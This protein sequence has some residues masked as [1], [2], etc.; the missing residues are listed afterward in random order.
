MDADSS[1]D[2]LKKKKINLFAVEV[3]LKCRGSAIEVL[4]KYRWTAVEVQTA[5]SHNHRP[6]PANSPT[7]HSRLVQKH[8]F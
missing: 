2:Y 8:A 5:N 6:S 3:A 7:I 1:N 4:L